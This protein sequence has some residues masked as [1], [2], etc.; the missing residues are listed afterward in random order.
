MA[1]VDVLVNISSLPILA[2]AFVTAVMKSVHYMTLE[3]VSVIEVVLS[4]VVVSVV[5]AGH[6]RECYLCYCTYGG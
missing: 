3:I 1:V 2:H 4:T 6:Y 5:R